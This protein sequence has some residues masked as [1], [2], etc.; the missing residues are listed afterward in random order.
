[1]RSLTGHC[2]LVAALTVP[3]EARLPLC[4]SRHSGSTVTHGYKSESQAAARTPGLAG[5]TEDMSLRRGLTCVLLLRAAALLHAAKWRYSGPEGEQDWSGQ[6]PYCGGVFQSPIHITSDLLRFDP[7][8]GAVALHNYHLP[9]HEQLTLGNN[10]HSVQISL[11]SR[12]YISS[13][14]DRYTT[15][16]LHFHW[17]SAT[18]P[19]GSEHMVNNKQYAGE[20][21][22][23]HFNSEKY[24]NMSVAVDKSDGLAVLGVFIEIG[25]YNAAYDQFLKFLNGIKYRGQKVQVPGFNIRDLFPARLDEYYRTTAL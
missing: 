12:M 20:M 7:S 21:H 5:L 1:M 10:G 2:S 18:R 14:P 13:L 6:F 24:P 8:L 17:G 22:V 9:P 23:V 16:Q 11:P 15:A 4:F 19:M 25:G 3:P